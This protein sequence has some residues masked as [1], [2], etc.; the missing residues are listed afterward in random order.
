M[1]KLIS[2]IGPDILEI[3]RRLGQ[4]KESVRYRY[5]AKIL[6]KGFAVQ[7][8]VAYEKLGLKRV[9]FV[10]DFHKDFKPYANTIFSAMSELCYVVYF[11]KTLPKGVY[12]VHAAVPAEFVE[13]YTEF[14]LA[15]KQRG[16]F[17]S[18]EVFAFE[19]ARNPPMRAEFYDFV[20]GRWEFDW[21]GPSP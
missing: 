5:K 14:I 8:A 11:A 4:F 16:L 7:A 15:L 1:V 3:S 17:S 18:V 20:A 19:W 13:S 2:E 10:A 12:A 6:G 21:S 9:I